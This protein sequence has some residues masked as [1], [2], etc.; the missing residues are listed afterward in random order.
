VDFYVPSLD[1]KLVAVAL[2]ENGSEDSAAHVFEVATEE[3]RDRVRAST[4]LPPEQHRV[5][6]RQFGF[7]YTRYPQGDE[8]PP[9]TPISIS[10]FTFIDSAPT[11]T[12]QIRDRQGF[13]RIAEI[14]LRASGNRRWLVATVANGDGASSRIT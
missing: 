11:P 2:S 8:R 12:G 6:G 5:E 3:L 14:Q 10:R 13:P 9:R 4:S 7:Y 1:G